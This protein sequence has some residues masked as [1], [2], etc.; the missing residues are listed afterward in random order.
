MDAPI[1]I[2]HSRPTLP[3]DWSEVTAL[4]CPPYVAQGPCVRRFEEELARRMGGVGAVATN[5]GTTA[6]HLILAAMG[7]GPGDEVILPAYVCAAVMHAVRYVGATPVLADIEPDGYNLCPRSVERRITRRTRAI[8]V[9]HMFGLAARM[10]ELLALGVPVIEDVAQALG[11]RWRGQ[12]L[13]SLGVASAVSFYATKVI[14]TGEGGAVVSR[15]PELLARV[16][17]LTQ[18]DQRDDPRLRFSCKMSEL[19]AALGLWQLQRLD[20]FFAIRR[21]LK[22]EYDGGL[23]NSQAIPH[24]FGGDEICYRYVVRIDG[25]VEERL[26]QFRARGV[27]ASRPVYRPLTHLTGD[28]DCPNSERAYRETISLP[29]YPSLTATERKH[30]LRVAGEIFGRR[31]RP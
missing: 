20:E 8:V 11:S 16:R 21:Q 6:L 24:P 30:V 22:E 18:Y 15:D 31:E 28:R 3:D 23:E 1:T 2:P 4:L 26:R 29:I 14:T 13:G 17:D 9:A 5:S 12:P 27:G 19:Q 7:I 10:D 25:E